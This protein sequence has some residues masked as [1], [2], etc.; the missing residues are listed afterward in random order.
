MGKTTRGT[1]ATKTFCLIVALLFLVSA[2]GGMAGKTETGTTADVI[3]SYTSAL[4]TGATI[5]EQGMSLCKDLYE[6][7]VIDKALRDKVIAVAWKY[8]ASYHA[9]VKA[10]DY[11]MKFKDASGYSALVTAMTTYYTDKDS[12]TELV[13]V[14]TAKGVKK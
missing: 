4:K 6:T 5:Y 1:R 2:C 14:L 7:K 13:S 8:W 12:L 11:Y 3:A 10:L 9:A